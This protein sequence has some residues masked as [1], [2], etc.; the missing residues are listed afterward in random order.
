[1]TRTYPPKGEF[2]TFE[3]EEHYTQLMQEWG[4]MGKVIKKEFVHKQGNKEQKVEVVGYEEHL[5]SY[6][7]VIRF[8]DGQLSCIQPAYLKEMQD[9]N[10]TAKRSQTETENETPKKTTNKAKKDKPDLLTLPVE[11]VAITAVVKGFDTQKN[12]FSDRDDEFLLLQDVVITSEPELA[13]GDAWCGYSNTLKKQE[14]AEGDTLAFEAK[15]V[16]KTFKKTNFYKI[17]NPS[18]IVKN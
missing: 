16:Q 6:T 15:I 1:M 18:K 3:S 9:T 10:F 8:A 14:L 17:N 12:P 2:M 13:V 7:A 11:K 4:L 5:P